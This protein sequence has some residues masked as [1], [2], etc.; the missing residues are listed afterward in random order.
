MKLA[1][2]LLMP[3]LML[4][5]AAATAAESI[6]C[7][8]DTPV[9]LL[10]RI[11]TAPTRPALLIGGSTPAL[12][13]VD[14]AT[15]ALLWSAD[16]ADGAMQRFPAMTAPFAGSLIALDTDNDGVQ[17]RLYAGDMAGRLWRF[18][19]HDGAPATSWA[20]G[21]VFA[22]FSNDAGRGF[23]APADVSLMA[24]GGAAP[25]FNVAIGTAAP[26]RSGAN[27]RFYVLRDSAPFVA[28]DDA[29]YRAWQPVREADLLRI[30]A[31]TPAD[32]AISAGWF[33]E[34]G[35]GDV[36]SA[37]L[38][39]AGR[40]VFAVA[41]SGITPGCRSAFTVAALDLG[42]PRLTVDAT[43]NW[44]QPLSP[45]LAASASFTLT[46]P[47]AGTEATS[48]RCAFGDTPVAACD[49]D[50]RPHRTWWRREDAE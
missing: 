33:V 46:M 2:L 45:E 28:W 35:S 34:L 15:G 39:V 8:P 24:P 40:V 5:G 18:D 43:G 36:L 29:Q 37:S 50:L 38:T 10:V 48:A 13:V 22:D 14:A 11:G 47:P 41:E 49:V 4:A 31:G 21:A 32:V 30:T 44:R 20:S 6:A 7:L 42:S 27:N 12:R 25:W 17:D 1:L 16:G 19:L 3:V 9:P 26:G 23:L